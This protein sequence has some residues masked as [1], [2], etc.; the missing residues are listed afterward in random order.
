MEGAT[1]HDRH[2]RRQKVRI[3]VT[4]LSCAA[5]ATGLERRL[6]RTPGL[7]RVTVNPITETLYA[8]F[9]PALLSL[10]KLHAEIE[11][12]GYGIRPQS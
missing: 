5:D 9:D 10:A 1:V 2:V 11:R 6:R 7:E 4:G 3:D 8:T 12:A